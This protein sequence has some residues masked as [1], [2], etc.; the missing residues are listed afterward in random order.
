MRWLDNGI[1]DLQYF[2]REGKIKKSP[3][4]AIKL[5]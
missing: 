4:H 2:P 5:E 3:E 1:V